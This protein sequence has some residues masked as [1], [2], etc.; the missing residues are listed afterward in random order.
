LSPGDHGQRHEVAPTARPLRPAGWGLRLG[1]LLFFVMLFVPTT[2]QW[3]KAVLLVLVLGAVASQALLRGHLRLHSSIFLWTGFMVAISLAFMLRGVAHG[4]PGVLAVGRVFVLWPLVFAILIAGAATEHAISGLLRV[5]VAATVAVGLYGFSYVLHAA[6]WLPNAAYIPLDQGQAIG[7]Y[8]GY[9]EFNLYSLAS[10]LFVVPFTI[11]ALFT[12]PSSEAP[13][14]RFWLW[15]A[16][17]LGLGLATLSARRALILTVAAAPVVALALRSLL[18]R[19]D[20]RASRKLV[21]Q[22]LV[23]GALTVV[24]LGFLLHTMYGLTLAGVADM[25]KQGFAFESYVRASVRK[26]QFLNLVTGW[27]E[28][29]LLGAGHGAVAPGW[30]RSEDQPWAYE[31]SYVALLF[32]TGLLGFMAYAAGVAWILWMGLRIIRSGGRLGL[33]M[34]PVLVG[35]ICFLLANATNPYLEKYDYMWVIFLPLAVINGWLLTRERE[36]STSVGRPMSELP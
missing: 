29:P 23:S 19:R 24:A 9:V 15:T 25:F 36:G 26:E 11:G 5:L 33:Y 22:L 3:I 1:F 35:T 14:S 21:A 32:H 6:G 4:A 34:L 10:L 31:L 28:A 8:A 7:F 18:P 16:L 17:V 20:R 12:W 27:T 30:L 13:V 2:Y